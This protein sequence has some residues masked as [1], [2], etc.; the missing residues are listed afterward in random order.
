MSLAPVTA[1]ILRVFRSADPDQLADGMSWYETAHLAALELSDEHGLS[2]VQTSGIIA[3]LSPQMSWGSNLRW[4]AEVASGQDT[5]RG[6]GLS[7]QR[8]IR[9][10][11]GESPL[12]SVLGGQK[13]RAFFHGIITA[14][15]TNEV[16]VD[17]HAYDLATGSRGNHTSLTPKRYVATA[18]A[19]RAASV[20]L[21]ATGEEL[22]ISAAQ[23]QAVT[24]VTW[25]DRYWAPG[26]WS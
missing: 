15:D 18:D 21:K 19:Y 11:N 13:V 26:A 9:I 12:E 2:I 10:R 3:A 5:R 4:A 6:L 20:R 22:D 1:R 17:R 8:A 23:V 14:G 7:L 24:W 16:C 25:R